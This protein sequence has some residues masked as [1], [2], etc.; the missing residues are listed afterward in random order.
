[1]AG[2]LK[3]KRTY[4][5]W[6]RVVLF[7]LTITL[8]LV[9]FAFVI[10]NNFTTGAKSYFFLKESHAFDNIAQI[11]KNELNDNLPDNIKNNF[12]KRA[13]VAKITDT[14]VTPENVAKVAEPA[15][16][17]MYNLSG[18]DTKL[19]DKKIVFNTYA[20]KSQAEQYL[21]AVG[22]P[23]GL[24]DTTSQF[25]K[26]VPDTIRILDIAENPNSPLALIVKLQSIFKIISTI[27]NA[28]LWVIIIGMLSV[29]LL[30]IKNFARLLKTYC[31]AFGISGAIVL[32]ISYGG[33]MISSSLL[34]ESDPANALANNLID[35]FCRLTRSYGWVLL[36]IGAGAL[37]ISLVS[38]TA[39]ARKLV[40]STRQSM[41]AFVKKTFSK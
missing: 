10:R 27:T 19:V 26:S 17:K 3:T 25:I 34:T 22:L 32:A 18:E 4:S 12:I 33:P 28:L 24:A 35:N 29:F 41:S 20:F 5:G 39:L 40:T 38:N 21:P 16:I 9:S 8:V 1:M 15:I 14:I 31:F 36:S 37:L 6:N 11:A 23:Q 7:I 30:N 13:I 2:G